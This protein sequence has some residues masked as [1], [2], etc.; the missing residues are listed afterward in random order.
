M[1]P[2]SSQSRTKTPTFVVEIPL[3]V[4]PSEARVLLS[5]LEV[6]RQLYN[7]CD[8]ESMRR[9]NLVKQSKLY[10]QAKRKK[11]GAERNNLFKQAREQQDYSEYGIHRYST[12]IRKSWIGE[13]IDSTTAQKLATRAFNAS[14]KVA[15]GQ[16]K[17]VRFK[18]KNQ[19]DTVEGKS[20][21]TG[22]RWKSEK[23]LWD[24]LSLSPLIDK[25]DPVILHG[26][27]SSIKYVRIVRRFLN[28][29]HRFYAQLICE[30]KPFIKPKNQLGKGTVGIDIG[31]STIAIVGEPTA[32]LLLF[33]AEI[34]DASKSVRRLQRQIDRQRRANNPDNYNDDGTSKKGKHTGQKSIRQKKVETKKAN[35]ERSL[36]AHRKS[37]H[38]KLVNEILREGD[39]FKLEKLSYKAFQKLYGKS[40]GKR[41]PSMFVSHLRSKAESAG[42]VVHEFNT[43]KTALSQSCQCGARKKKKLSERVHKCDCGVIAQ[44]DLY[45][46]FL[47]RF[48]DDKNLL[49]ADLASLAWSG[50]EPFLWAACLQASINNLRVGGLVPSSF[51]RCPESERIAQKVLISNT[52]IL[53]VVVSNNESQEQVSS[54]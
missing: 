15:F 37:L 14:Q 12:Y 13:H 47:A 7:A 28:G 24:G 10:Q 40:V 30:G 33:C 23:L 21:K 3:K 53:D 54:S 22:I 18:G 41:A 51:G 29:C 25:N 8:S 19:L 39:E 35:I 20:N 42:G 1:S 27:N 9:L 34:K 26:L 49:Q 11:K 16:A 2:H 50:A 32:R 45:S 43:Y 36:A 38:G 44:R 31:P 48:V 5:R 6:A 52:K 4:S 17:K 46:A